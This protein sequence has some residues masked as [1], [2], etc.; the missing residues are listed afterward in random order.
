MPLIFSSFWPVLFVSLYQSA[1]FPA[2][3]SFLAVLSVMQIELRGDSVQERAPVPNRVL[4]VFFA[5]EKN[6][7]VGGRFEAPWLLVWA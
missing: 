1:L 2:A 5:L 3:P 7:V 4:E 6:H